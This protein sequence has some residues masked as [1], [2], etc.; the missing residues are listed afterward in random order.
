MYNPLDDLDVMALTVWAEARGEGIKGQSAV[1]WVIRNRW[2]HPRW[3]SRH[4]D[5][6]PDDT[7]EAVCKDPW[8]FSCWNPNDPNRRLLDD[9]RTLEHPSLKNIRLICEKVLLSEIL[10]PTDRAD[11]Y[12][13]TKII[14]YTGWARGRKPVAVIGN[15]SFFRIEL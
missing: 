12:C 2:E 11:H 15:H 14:K 7:I 3:W 1:A 8:Q 5:G 4:R 9:A 6:I 10:D 13:T